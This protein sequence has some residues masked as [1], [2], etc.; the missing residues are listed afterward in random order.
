MLNKSTPTIGE[1]YLISHLEL[2]EKIY[3]NFISVRSVERP[4]QDVFSLLGK[5]IGR[6]AKST[7]TFSFD[8]KVI[9]DL[10]KYVQ[11]LKTLWTIVAEN[12]QGK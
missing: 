3:I 6:G 1:I 12:M 11:H 4:D 2:D 9:V 5:K 10:I 8:E 7:M